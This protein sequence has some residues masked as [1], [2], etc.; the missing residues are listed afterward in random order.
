MP[1]QLLFLSAAGAMVALLAACTRPA[2]PSDPPEPPSPY[3]TAAAGADGPGTAPGPG[4]FPLVPAT[5]AHVQLQCPLVSAVH[6]DAE[7]IPASDV[8]GVFV[9]TTT[10]YTD[11]PDG[12]P[13]IEE[14]VDRVASDDI[15]GLLAAYSAPDAERT[16][17]PCDLAL[18]DPLIVWLHYGDEQITPVYAPQDECG[19]P[20]ADASAAYAGLELHRILV[21]R[22]KTR[23]S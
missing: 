19:F 8:D 21:A 16:E 18:H 15:D 14:F 11:A 9:C 22:E 6:Y 10:P 3:V 7:A 13:Q 4:I 17:G 20:S 5:H 23:K 12:T 2:T 1:R